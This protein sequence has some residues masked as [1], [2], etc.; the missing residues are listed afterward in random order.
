VE[1][2]EA[3]LAVPLVDERAVVEEVVQHV[4]LAVGGREVEGRARAV[5]LE[6]CMYIYHYS[7]YVDTG[8]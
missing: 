2:G 7:S 3:V 1:G 8:I 5:V 6:M 4:E